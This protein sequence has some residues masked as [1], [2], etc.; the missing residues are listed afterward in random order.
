[1]A[2]AGSLGD[3]VTLL[4]IAYV[5]FLITNN[6]R[7]DIGD[8]VG[9]GWKRMAS[10]V[11][12]VIVVL[13][14][15]VGAGIQIKTRVID[16]IPDLIDRGATVMVPADRSRDVAHVPQGPTFGRY[17]PDVLASGRAARAC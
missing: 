8:A 9:R 12:L 2:A 6:R 3:C 13:M 11:V 5:M 7:S 10:N 16:R 15:I 1:M 4:P 14:S 17:S